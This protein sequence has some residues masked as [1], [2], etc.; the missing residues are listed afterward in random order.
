[1]ELRSRIEEAYAARHP[2]TLKETE[3]ITAAGDVR[4]LEI[5]VAPLVDGNDGM[6]DA[7]KRRGKRFTAKW[8]WP[9]KWASIMMC[10][11]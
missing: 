6:L 3:W 9:R 8:P 11:A 7:T 5:Q 1:M 10:E 4:F 2:V